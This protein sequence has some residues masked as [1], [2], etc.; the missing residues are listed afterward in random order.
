MTLHYQEDWLHLNSRL[1]LCVEKQRESLYRCVRSLGCHSSTIWKY[2]LCFFIYLFSDAIFEG[3]FWLILSF[4]LHLTVTS[5]FVRPDWWGT[6]ACCEYSWAS[7]SWRP[8]RTSERALLSYLSEVCLDFRQMPQYNS[9][10]LNTGHFKMIIYSYC[11]M[12]MCLFC[13]FHKLG[14][15]NICHSRECA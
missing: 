12:G 6:N 13:A 14:S 7:L 1:F 8:D 5:Q 10:L 15:G 9:Q 2:T 11:A 3:A 4:D